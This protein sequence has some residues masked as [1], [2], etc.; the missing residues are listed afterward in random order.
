MGAPTMTDICL[1]GQLVERLV[2]HEEAR[3]ETA[4]LIWA[5]LGPESSAALNAIRVNPVEDSRFDF[6]TLILA[7][8]ATY[9]IANGSPNYVGATIDAHWLFEACRT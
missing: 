5:L 2:D 8:L 6:S 3:P 9:V 7:D 4:A 1:L